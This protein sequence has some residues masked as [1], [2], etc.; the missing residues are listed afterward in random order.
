M[1]LVESI[2]GRLSGN[3]KKNRTLKTE[4]FH[5]VGVFYYEDNIRKLACRNPD[6]KF[7]TAQIISQG[8]AMQKIFRYNYINKPVKLISEPTNPHDRNAIVTI[9]AGE[10]VGYISRDDNIHVGNILKRHEIKYISSFISGGQYKIVSTGGDIN[11]L[12]DNISITV[13]IGYV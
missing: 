3:S 4:I 12:E 9:I 5:V 1:G 13:K 7:T 8:K 10:K 11:R 6:W 2:V